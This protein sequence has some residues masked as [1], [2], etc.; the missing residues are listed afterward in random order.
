M[1]YKIVTR[2]LFHRAC[3]DALIGLLE[4]LSQVIFFVLFQFHTQH[5]IVHQVLSPDDQLQEIVMW[6]LSFSHGK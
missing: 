4:T 2:Q 1:E 3:L 6:I 5:A